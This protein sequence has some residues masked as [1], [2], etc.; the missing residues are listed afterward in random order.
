MNANYSIVE[1]SHYRLFL[2]EEGYGFI[3]ELLVNPEG[4]VAVRRVNKGVDMEST[5]LI[6]IAEE[7]LKQQAPRK[8]R[9]RK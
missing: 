1:D 6:N 7:L 9:S 5:P 3:A 8:I 2:K 4:E